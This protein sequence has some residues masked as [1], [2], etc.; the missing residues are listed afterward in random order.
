M[1]ELESGATLFSDSSLRSQSLEIVETAEKRKSDPCDRFR[2]RQTKA[3]T[4][5]GLARD[6]HELHIFAS[7]ANFPFPSLVC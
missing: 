6:L 2:Q 4:S 7:S 3:C 5:T 1:S